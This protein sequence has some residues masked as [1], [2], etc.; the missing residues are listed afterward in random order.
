MHAVIAVFRGRAFA[1]SQCTALSNSI[2]R[3][4]APD[5]IEQAAGRDLQSVADS[6]RSGRAGGAPPRPAPAD[7]G[8]RE[9]MFDYFTADALSALAQVIMI[10]LVLAGDNAI[11]IGLAAAGLPKEQRDKAI[12]LGIVAA[13]VLRIVLRADDDAAAG[14]R[15]ACCSPAA[16]CCCGCAGRCGASCAAG[17]RTT[18]DA[19]STGAGYVDQSRTARSPVGAPR[20]TLRAGGRADHRRRRLDVARQRAGGRRRG[21]RA[22]DGCWS[23][24]SCCRSP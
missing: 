3:R 21:A 5:V 7:R 18:S 19:A 6:S 4:R 20:K 9:T 10:D 23:S 11:V 22:S 1:R 2:G 12:L 14:D 13:T 16:S 8:D 24:A 15:S 17:E